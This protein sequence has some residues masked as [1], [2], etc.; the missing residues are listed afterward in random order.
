MITS[1]LTKEEKEQIRKF[2]TKWDGYGPWGI[3]TKDG[4]ILK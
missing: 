2:A 1:P 4:T 3:T